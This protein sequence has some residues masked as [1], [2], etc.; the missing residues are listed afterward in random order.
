M[1]LTLNTTTESDESDHV[2]E[3]DEEEAAALRALASI[4]DIDLLPL[5]GRG[6]LAKRVKICSCGHFTCGM[7]VRFGL[8]VPTFTDQIEPIR[9]QTERD[10]RAL[11][12]LA[13]G[14]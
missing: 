8:P 2:V 13:G 9:S 1:Y 12:I 5:A 14:D 4:V 3:S 10:K 6:E 11:E 7:I